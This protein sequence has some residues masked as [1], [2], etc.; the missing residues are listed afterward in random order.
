[1]SKFEKNKKYTTHFITNSD[2]K[3][4]IEVISRTKKSI[5]FKVVDGENKVFQKKIYIWNEEEHIYPLGQYSMCPCVGA[6]DI[7]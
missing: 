2:L 6:S 3:L 7:V 5:K 1:M 4:E